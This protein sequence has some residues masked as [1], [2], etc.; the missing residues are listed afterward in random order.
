MARISLKQGS[1][2][3]LKAFLLWTNDLCQ[4]YGISEYRLLKTCNM[5]KNFFCDIRRQLRGETERRTKFSLF[6]L[7]VIC[8]YYP[9]EFNIPKYLPLLDVS[10]LCNESKTIEAIFTKRKIG[11]K[12][13]KPLT[14]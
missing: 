9:Y 3:D 7:L 10:P 11:N 12:L 1:D 8:R 13:K 5:R 14:N 6:L 4:Y 2:D